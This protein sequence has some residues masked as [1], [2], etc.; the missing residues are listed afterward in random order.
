MNFTRL[1]LVQ[2]I[3]NVLRRFFARVS[4]RFRRREHDTDAEVLSVEQDNTAA[5]AEVDGMDKC[6]ASAEVDGVGN[7]VAA[8]SEVAGMDKCDAVTKV[9]GVD[10]LVAAVGEVDGMDNCAALAEVDG[11][12]NCPAV[13]E[14]DGVNICPTYAEVYGPDICPT[15]A[16]VYGLDNFDAVA[17]VD[18]V[19]KCAAVDEVQTEQQA[20]LEAA[21]N[22]IEI[23]RRAARIRGFIH[24]VGRRGFEQVTTRIAET[25]RIEGVPCVVMGAANI[26]FEI[27]SASSEYFS[28]TKPTLLDPISLRFLRKRQKLEIKEF[29]PT[30]IREVRMHRFADRVCDRVRDWIGVRLDIIIDER[31]VERF[32]ERQLETL[33]E[34][35]EGNGMRI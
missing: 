1:Y 26:A 22:E 18:V 32:L 14:V 17:E 10:N 12:D 7:L 8:V 29:D 33:G 20:A 9:D 3:M 34:R 19:G 4:R 28:W 11:V 23:A 2:S 6:A 35:L 21:L 5:V 25:V 27:E 31:M 13:A 24:R 30:E 15:Y 16:E